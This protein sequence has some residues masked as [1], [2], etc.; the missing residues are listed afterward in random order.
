MYHTLP[1]DKSLIATL[2]FLWLVFH[3]SNLQCEILLTH[4]SSTFYTCMTL[5]CHHLKSPKNL[6]PWISHPL[7]SCDVVVMCY[8]PLLLWATIKSS[9]SICHVLYCAKA[10]STHVLRCFVYIGSSGQLAFSLLISFSGSVPEPATLLAC[11]HSVVDAL[12][13]DCTS[14]S[15]QVVDCSSFVIQFHPMSYYSCHGRCC[16][17]AATV[18]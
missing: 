17:C 15:P 3:T 9:P 5:D 4:S 16:C 7:R 10:N 18:D 14:P 2:V 6:F 11:I 1:L 8:C 13:A 12:H